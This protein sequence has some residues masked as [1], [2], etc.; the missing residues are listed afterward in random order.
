MNLTQLRKL[1]SQSWLSEEG[2]E[3]EL[4]RRLVE[5]DAAAEG[6]EIPKQS[7]SP[8]DVSDAARAEL[9]DVCLASSSEDDDAPSI[10]ANVVPVPVERSG[11]V[12]SAMTPQSGGRGSR[13]GS[14]PRAMATP[15]RPL[16]TSRSESPSDTS[17]RNRGLRGQG[18]RGMPS[19][20][21]AV[22]DTAL[23]SAPAV[24]TPTRSVRNSDIDS[25]R[26]P[27]LKVQE[28]DEEQDVHYGDK[29][30]G[31]HD[32]EEEAEAAEE[33]AEE[34]L[35]SRGFDAAA[36]RSIRSRFHESDIVFEVKSLQGLSF[37]DLWQYTKPT[38]RLSTNRLNKVE[39]E[40]EQADSVPA[41]D[42]GEDASEDD[43]IQLFSSPPA[44]GLNAR[45]ET[46]DNP[47]T[48]VPMSLQ[49]PSSPRSGHGQPNL[50]R[51]LSPMEEYAA[52]L[53]ADPSAI[54][55][56]PSVD[57]GVNAR[58]QG[59][60]AARRW[61]RFKGGSGSSGGASERSGRQSGTAVAGGETEEDDEDAAARAEAAALRARLL[62]ER[63]MTTSGATRSRAEDERARSSAAQTSVASAKCPPR[64][65]AEARAAL[66]S[67]PPQRRS[68]THSSGTTSSP[69]PL[70]TVGAEEELECETESSAAMYFERFDA[71]CDGRLSS[72]TELGAALN[73]AYPE[74]QLEPAELEELREEA[75]AEVPSDTG[76]NLAGLSLDQFAFLIA[77]FTSE[78]GPPQP[79]KRL[80]RGSRGAPRQMNAGTV[81]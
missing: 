69:P 57:T 13:Y 12:K 29:D 36:V 70:P 40:A 8:I 73:S 35:K 14:V 16:S 15:S 22:D 18:L 33:E 11:R 7:N 80:A 20:S 49:P 59:K 6:W 63:G 3:D 81:I 64:V 37:D 52:S 74:L 51:A 54:C 71:D 9:E 2:S 28:D 46:T 26:L 77:G 66:L 67:T 23:P 25:S 58:R 1:C 31:N 47:R 76:S 30:D 56:D 61:G 78:M 44:Q 48:Q 4:K 41:R 34:W 50:Q 75:Q 43:D 39:H 24:S 5:Y 55:T 38:Y 72:P 53:R 68:R 10:S 19:L 60:G 65:P 21:I 45:R 17:S 79:L 27:M 32:E 42:N 62:A